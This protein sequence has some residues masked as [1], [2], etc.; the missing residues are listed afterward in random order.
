MGYLIVAYLLVGLVLGGY[1]LHLER[2]RRMLRRSAR[3]R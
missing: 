3:H 2:R 1:A